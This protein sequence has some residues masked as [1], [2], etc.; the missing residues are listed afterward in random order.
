M[1]ENDNI[2]I[3]FFSAA[4]GWSGISMRLKQAE[5]LTGTPG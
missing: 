1:N 2:R 5:K 3:A 4:P